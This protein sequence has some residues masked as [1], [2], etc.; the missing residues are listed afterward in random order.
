[1]GEPAVESTWRKLPAMCAL[2]AALAFAVMLGI[3]PLSSPDIGY[4]I[5]YGQEFLRTGRLVDHNDYVFLGNDAAATR[6]EPGPGCWYDAD[7]RYRFPNANWL[8]Q[9]ILAAIYQAFGFLGLC[10]LQALLTAGAFAAAV[11]AMRRLG[12]GPLAIAVGVLLI[13]LASY[14]RLVLRPEM[15][16]YLLLA[17]QLAILM[18]AYRQFIDGLGRDPQNARKLSAPVI[19]AILG[20]QLLLTNLHSYFLLGLI[21]T[22]AILGDAIL[23]TLWSLYR[24][25][26]VHAA[27]KSWTCRAALLLGLQMAVCFANPW[28]WRTVLLPFQTLVFLHENNVGEEMTRLGHPWQMI[29]EFWRPL[30]VSFA[31]T[32]VTYVHVAMLG[33]A[34][35]A[36]ACSMLRRRWAYAAL[37][38][39]TA[40]VSTSM[41]RN[42]APAS[43]LLVPV[44]LAALFDAARHLRENH[45]AQRLARGL[46]PAVAAKPSTPRKRS[47]G[48]SI[49]LGACTAA[50]GVVGIL[51]VATQ[52]FYVSERSHAR[53]GWGVSRMEVPTGA[54][55]FIRANLPGRQRIWTDFFSSSNLH[56][57][58]G[59]QVPVLTN[60]W[61]YPPDALGAYLKYSLGSTS[62][63]QELERRQIDVAAVRVDDGIAERLSSTSA[64][65]E[66]ADQWTMVYFDGMYA[67]FVDPKG[68]SVDVAAKCGLPRNPPS[69]P[70]ALRTRIEAMDSVPAAAFHAS[71]L[72]LYIMG[73]DAAAI[74]AFE[75]A[76]RHDGR[77]FRTW[78][79]LGVCLARRATSLS[80]ATQPDFL[81]AKADLTRARE[82]FHNAVDR[83]DNEKSRKVVEANLARAT[84]DLDALQRG[85][86]VPAP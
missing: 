34:G 4:H 17:V 16:S 59:S 6:A 71:G 40:V 76:A 77:Y 47:V 26:P 75:E 83:C 78:N 50:L 53:F 29:G 13:A 27:L 38:A 37:L 35:L 2:A 36:F 20:V 15:F 32:R 82:C 43:I 41:R 51:S 79:M 30:G 5:A 84:A 12:L 3:R 42:V 58:T 61:A 72:S 11:V 80:T 60:T 33:L 73:W 62:L 74:D 63:V 1:M 57:L 31:G 54:A 48:V 39:A 21:A 56:F 64:A 14:E 22:G 55:E 67:V 18:P 10:V 45:V 25:Q 66:L 46:S 24:K 28:T 9:V 23:R 69:L 86:V 70:P 49:A 65:R 8:T 52:H 19:V 81:A 68:P 44:T 7:G 85:E